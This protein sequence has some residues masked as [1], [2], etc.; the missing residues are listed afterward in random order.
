MKH[1]NNGDSCSSLLE[2]IHLYC[3]HTRKFCSTHLIQ[4][5]LFLLMIKKFTMNSEENGR[6]ITMFQLCLEVINLKVKIQADK[7]RKCPTKTISKNL[8]F[9]K[10]VFSLPHSD[11]FFS[12]CLVLYCSTVYLSKAEADDILSCTSIESS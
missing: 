4:L 6:N 5:P 3:Y 7:G 9:F 8:K 11:F 1:S 12:F 2:K 10:A